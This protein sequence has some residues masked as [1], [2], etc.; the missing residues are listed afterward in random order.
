MQVPTEA[1]VSRAG[2]ARVGEACAYLAMSRASLYGMMENGT[3]R[4]VKLGRSRR[5]PWA[6]LETL[7]EKGTNGSTDADH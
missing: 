3:L 4:Y 1:K 2:L 5:I 6:A 7:A